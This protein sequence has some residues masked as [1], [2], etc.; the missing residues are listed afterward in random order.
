M[1]KAIIAL[2]LT[3]CMFVTSCTPQQTAVTALE[4]V[5]L[6]ATT[7]IPTIIALEAVGKV[8]PATAAV[9]LQYAKAVSTAS[10]LAATELNS[11]DTNAVKVSVVIADF[12]PV[13]APSL[14]A[15][16]AP[17]VFAA[18]QAIS[19]A[20][21]LFITN[22]KSGQLVTAARGASGVAQLNLVKLSHADK[23]KLVQIKKTSVANV[24]KVNAWVPAH[25]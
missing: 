23:T 24:A 1:K 22:L 10:S 11:S 3:F 15:N 8:D 19:S 12:E 7:A 4:A 6:A 25:K 13:V 16:V 9:A 20:I 5:S 14:G 17:E 2:M 18:V 21:Q